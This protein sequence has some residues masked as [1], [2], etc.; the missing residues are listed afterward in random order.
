MS[1]AIQPITLAEFLEWEAQQAEKYE[2][3]G[4]E[5]IAM[6]GGSPR[7]SLLAAELQFAVRSL[8]KLP[9]RLYQ[10]DVKVL[11]AGGSRARYPDAS[12]VCTPPAEGQDDVEPVVVF[13]VSS[14]ST[15]LKDSRVKAVEYQQTP[16]IMVYVMLE[17]EAP[18]AHIMRRSTG[19]EV[20]IVSDISPG[21]AWVN[22]PEVGISFLLA[23]IYQ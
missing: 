4:I 3:D 8:L 1:A 13:E 12:I 14:P 5:P 10:S 20:E 2:F 22:L 17:T 11:T 18:R 21:M 7:H 23:E 19:W 9:C 15:R 6:T 16:S